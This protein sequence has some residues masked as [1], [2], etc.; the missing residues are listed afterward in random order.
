MTKSRIWS[1]GGRAPASPGEA[2]KRDTAPLPR[3]RPGPG[4]AD[5]AEALLLM[6]SFEDSGQG[7]FWATDPEGQLTYISDGIA[8]VL[9]G[10]RE[11]LVGARFADLFVPADDDE[12][13]RRP[14][15]FILAKQSAFEKIILCA[16]EAGDGRCWS[17]SGWPQFEPSGR[18]TGFRGS[19]ID[20]TEQRRIVR[21]RLAA[22]QI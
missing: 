8:H 2:S 21:A 10:D 16:A 15:P 20:V 4:G 17:V 6:R 18:F 13:G 9:D 5:P 12:S 11:P 3:T 7:W 22:G 19:A 14:L 1:F